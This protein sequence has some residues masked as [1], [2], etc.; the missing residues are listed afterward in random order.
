MRAK[1]HHPRGSRGRVVTLA[2]AA[3]ATMAMSRGVHAGTTGSETTISISGSTAIRNF[4]TSP[5]FSLVTPGQQVSIN[6]TLYPS[7]SNYWP[8]N[9]SGVS[10]QLAPSAFPGAS[11]STTFGAADALRL[12]WHEQGS[13]EGILELAN[14]QIAPL[15]SVTATNRNPTSGNPV[16][17]NGNKFVG[18]STIGGFLVGDMYSSPGGTSGQPNFAFSG[19]NPNGGQNAVQM[20]I[21]DVSGRQ[22]FSVAGAGA[23]NKRPGDSGYGKGNV[24]LPAGSTTQGLGQANI[25]HELADQTLLNMPAA[26]TNP[27]TGAAFGSGPWNTAGID[28]LDNQ[29]VAIT[30]T[31]FVAN[32]GTGLDRI[33]RSDAQFLQAAGRLPNG[34]DFNAATR[35]V[36]SG[37]LN[38]AALNVGLDPSFAVGENDDGNGNAADG[39]TTQVNIGPG[40]KFSNKTSG[41]SGV[42]PTVQNARM[43]IGHLSISDSIGSTKNSVSRP[44]RALA[45]RDDDNDVADNSNNVYRPAIPT[46]DQRDAYTDPASGEF[47]LASGSNI[48]GGKYVI[49]QNETYL[50]VKKPGAA[51]AGDTPAQWAARSSTQTGIQGDTATN[52]VRNFRDNVLNAVASFPLPTNLANAASPADG[53]LN[54]SLILPQLMAVKKTGDGINQSVANSSQNVA[55]ANAF[56]DPNNGLVQAFNPAD[57]NTVTKGASSTYGAVT[58]AGGQGAIKITDQNYLFGNFLQNGVRDFAAVLAAQDAQAK[59]LASGAG[60]DMFS[61]SSNATVVPGVAAP[62]ATMTNQAGGTGATKGDLIVLGDYNADGKFDGKD[63]YQLAHGAALANTNTGSGSNGLTLGAGETFGQAI[64]RGML[65]KNA[66]LD[67]LNATATAQQKIDASA[68]LTNDPTGA[69]AFNKL[70]VNRDGLVSRFDA[71]IVDGFQDKDYRKL[72]DQLSAVITDAQG[73]RIISLVDAELN[74]TGDITRAD[75][76]IVKTSL[77]AAGKLIPGDAN[78]DGIVNVGDLGLLSTNFGSPT[79]RWG[80]GDFNGDG[81]VNVGDLGLLSTNFGANANTGAPASPIDLSEA[82]ALAGLDP[83]SVPEP[84]SIAAIG[85]S[86]ISLLRRRRK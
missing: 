63:L 39:G 85:L 47:T 46:G 86:A 30:A 35:D 9:G 18:T 20:A 26:T 82:I 56:L 24:F 28:N 54:T 51:F 42:R 4:T 37:T 60:V 52:D 73:T 32:P 40:I 10:F 43:A 69:N 84:S 44:L 58:P 65:L 6:G 78:F 3:A 68:N 33:N 45:Y 48:L 34:A 12:E 80:L 55:L 36:N 59:L 2:A 75:F 57:P 83:A 70:D 53:L 15:G 7:S 49:Y 23:F 72:A 61:G 8:T 62:L 14:D 38:V 77:V 16:W 22:G 76:D 81:I 71:K 31:L 11:G 25:H 19:N 79:S 29:T 13:V 50:T 5:S 74:D 17:V 66:A 1:P 67:L 27:R 64:R 41:G 21:S